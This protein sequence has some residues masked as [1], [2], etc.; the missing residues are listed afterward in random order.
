MRLSAQL[1]YMCKRLS[2]TRGLRKATLPRSIDNRFLVALS[3]VV[4]I[5]S[6]AV[7]FSGWAR[8]VMFGAARFSFAYLAHRMRRGKPKK[9]QLT[10]ASAQAMREFMIAKQR[11]WE[12]MDNSNLNNT[13]TGGLPMHEEDVADRRRGGHFTE[14]AMQRF[15]RRRR[16]ED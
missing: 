6:L 16:S 12:R 2:S 4:I 9:T 3:S 10:G 14:I 5:F 13:N 1:T 8:T 7:A 15:W 11:E